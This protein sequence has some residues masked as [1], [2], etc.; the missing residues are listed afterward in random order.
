MKNKSLGKFLFCVLS[1]PVC[2]PA[3]TSAL[4]CFLFFCSI[5]RTQAK[6]YIYAKTNVSKR[7]FRDPLYIKA[8]QAIYQAGF[9]AA[10]LLKNKNKAPTLMKPK[11]IRP[12]DLTGWVKAEFKSFKV[13]CCEWLGCA[14]SK[15]MYST[16]RSSLQWML[17][18]IIGD[19]FKE[20]FGNAFAQAIHDGVTLENKE[21]C[22]ALGIQFVSPK[23]DM[24]LVLA[25]AF[26]SATGG[27]MEEIAAVCLLCFS[28]ILL[29]VVCVALHFSRR[30]YPFP[31]T[32][33]YHKCIVQDCRKQWKRMCPNY[34]WER[35][36]HSS[37]QD[38]HALG[39]SREFGFDEEICNMHLDDKLMRSG[40]GVLTRSKNKTVIN[41]FLDGKDLVMKNHKIATHCCKYWKKKCAPT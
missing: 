14:A 39:V 9:A 16:V 6:Y 37:C 40:L 18:V 31:K 20:S 5:H 33:I 3:L 8:A 32:H 25:V 7:T 10:K 36:F 21:K 28:L 41:P 12:D 26:S 24:N 35:V 29:V 27:T 17:N 34:P 11:L 13:S 30:A 23:L 2:Y 38:E 4:T 1:S 15:L 22:N 19:C